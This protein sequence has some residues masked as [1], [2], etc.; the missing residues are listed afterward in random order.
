MHIP[1]NDETIP[2]SPD[3]AIEPLLQ[4]RDIAAI[5]RLKDPESAYR[6]PIRRLKFGRSVFWHPQDVRLFI[7]L[8]MQ[9]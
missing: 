4:A 3:G 8:H 5:F 1:T 7:S 6:L 2:V 9:G